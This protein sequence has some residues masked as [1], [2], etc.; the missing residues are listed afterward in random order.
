MKS[1]HQK[2]VEEFM[3]L[4]GQEIPEVPTLPDE[5]TRLLRSK[6]ILEEALETI[7]ALGFAVE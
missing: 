7:H 6:L 4:A 1:P 5:K 2:R 3:R